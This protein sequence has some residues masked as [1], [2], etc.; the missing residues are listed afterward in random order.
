VRTKIETGAREQRAAVLDDLEFCGKDED[1]KL[2]FRGHAAVFDEWAQ[3]GDPSWGFLES[4]KRGAFR[5]VLSAG[6]DV[7]FLINH[8]G[9]PLARTASGTMK[10]KEDARGL[11]VDAELAPT[12]LAQDLSV[13]VER[14]DVSQ[15]SFGFRVGKHEIEEDEETGAV[16]RTIT[17]F[18]ELYDVSPVTFP[19]Y[20]GT[21]AGMRAAA[22]AE[23]RAAVETSPDL[24]SVFAQSGAAALKTFLADL[25]PEDRSAEEKPASGLTVARARLL[26]AEIG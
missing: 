11:L 1:G 19:A 26:L 10:L 16:K 2:Q 12:T 7:R 8:E 3:I 4:V 18:S 22:L 6:A 20:E 21:D 25:L 15:M 14:G 5:K 23:L 13:L 17:E 9:L 24:A